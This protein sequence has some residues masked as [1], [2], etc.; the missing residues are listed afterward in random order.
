[1][2]QLHAGLPIK[3]RQVIANYYKA[4]IDDIVS[5]D[6]HQALPLPRDYSL[7]VPFLPIYIG[8]ACGYNSCRYLT[9]SQSRIRSHLNQEHETYRGDCQAYIRHISLQNWYS[10]TRSQYWIVQY[11]VAKGDGKLLDTSIIHPD[12]RSR[13]QTQSKRSGKGQA[14]CLSV[15]HALQQ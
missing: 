7:L 10:N 8:F 14:H 2:G 6:A 3:I 9:Q 15:L 1:L 5:K 12:R 11:P 4:A 13:N